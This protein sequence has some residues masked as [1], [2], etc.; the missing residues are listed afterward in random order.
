MYFYI[1]KKNGVYG[2]GLAD[3]LSEIYDLEFYVQVTTKDVLIFFSEICIEQNINT[4]VGYTIIC[5]MLEDFAANE[6]REVY[7]SDN[8]DG[9][10]E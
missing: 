9:E 7:G 8:S 5:D 1:T 3:K 6:K 4:Q 10:S 2:S